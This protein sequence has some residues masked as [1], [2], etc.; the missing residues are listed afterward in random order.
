LPGD[1]NYKEWQK[2]FSINLWSSTNVIEASKKYL[3]LSKGVIICISSICGLEV[4][5]GAPVTYSAAKAALHAYVKGVSKPFGKLG[6]RIN[7][8]A[9]GNIIFNGSLWSEKL[10][11]QPNSTQNMLDEEVSISRFG[12]PEEVAD[13]VKFIAF[14]NNGF[15]NGSVWTLDGGQVRS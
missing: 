13:L 11:N 12:K 8:I 7:A 2:S 1:E 4:V 14:K 5:K 9:L 10:K 15:I 6:I 3:E